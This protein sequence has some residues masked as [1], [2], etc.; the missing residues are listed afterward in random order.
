MDAELI[1]IWRGEMRESLHR[2]HAVICDDTGQVVQAWGN[3]NM[4]I[5][6]RSSAKPIQALA[7]L[8]AGVVLSEERLALS[9]ASHSGAAI[10]T[11]RVASW[12]SEMDLTDDAFRCGGQEP[13]DVPARDGLI[14]AGE[15]PRQIH[16]NCSGKHAGFLDFSRHLC[17]G[18]EY[19]DID[20]PVQ[21]AVKAAFEEVT[22]ETS[23]HWAVDGCSAPNHACT[24]S[25]LARAG[26]KFAAAAEDST[27][28]TAMV[29]LRNAMMAF[30]ELVAGEGRSCTDLMRACRGKAAVKTG[31]EGVYLA[32]LPELRKGVAVKITDGATRAAEAAMAAIL[33]LL[34]VAD[35]QDPLVAKYHYA[36]IRNRRDI[37]TGEMRPSPALQ[38]RTLGQL[39]LGR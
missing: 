39:G 4:L 20:H 18:P 31:A 26:A 10:H 16:N 7:M 15:A 25:G 30:P 27:R 12:L 36:Q 24:L 22:G 32:I 11:D 8:E 17:A 34:G 38:G 19:V 14:C 9:C 1:E 2:G 23:P 21:V 29:A 37:V 28:G 5:Y 13:G 35:R 6:P 33:V 3:P